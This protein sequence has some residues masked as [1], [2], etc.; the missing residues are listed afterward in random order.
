MIFCTDDQLHVLEHYRLIRQNYDWLT[1]VLDPD[2]GLLPVLFQRHVISSR[3]YEQIR[4][5]IDQFTRNE[6]LLFIISRKSSEDFEHF[7]A[8]LNETNQQTIARRLTL[9]EPSM[10]HR[11]TFKSST[12]FKQTGAL[13]LCLF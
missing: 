11:Y 13:A 7:K 4:T 8:A 1:E 3:E 2:S 6:Y 10:H 5:S 12:H 9:K